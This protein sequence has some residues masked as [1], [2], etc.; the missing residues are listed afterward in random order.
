MIPSWQE[1]YDKPRQCVEKQRHYSAD[2]SLYSQGCGL[3]SGHVQ[4][5]ES[6]IIKRSE[7]Q[8]THLRTVWSS[9][10]L[11]MWC[12]ETGK[13]MGKQWKLWE[14]IFLGSKITAYGDCSHRIK[15]HLLLG[16]KIMRNL[17]S[18]LNS[19][20]ITLLTKVCLLKAM[21][22]PVVMY[23]CESWSIMKT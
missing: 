12:E 2:K 21:V 16:R 17:D 15:R 13:W 4:L 5:W 7:R 9:S 3:P 18:I 11:V 8:R 19:K 23:G 20:D 6:W 1:S 22:F 14:S 10:I